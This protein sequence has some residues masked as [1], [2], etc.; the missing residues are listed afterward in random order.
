MVPVLGMSQEVGEDG[1]YKGLVDFCGSRWLNPTASLG[2]AKCLQD[3]QD[4]GSSDF[5][6]IWMLPNIRALNT[7]VVFECPETSIFLTF[8]ILPA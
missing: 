7:P 5:P 3:I 6:Q 8:V 2:R 1:C 4:F